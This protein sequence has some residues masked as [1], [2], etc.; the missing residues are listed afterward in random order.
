MRSLETLSDGFACEQEA[1]W[2]DAADD[3]SGTIASSKLKNLVA[4][5]YGYD[6]PHTELH[7][8]LSA[9]HYGG[10]DAPYCSSK[11]GITFSRRRFAAQGTSR[12]PRT[13]L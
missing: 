11:F 2:L 12:T 1:F 9:T 10:T 7:A 6:L 13:R 8:L 4:Q 5:V 3:D